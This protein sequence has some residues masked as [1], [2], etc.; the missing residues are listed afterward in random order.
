MG[1]WLR[2]FP[3]GHRFSSQLPQGSPQLSLI[4]VPEDSMTSSGP[5]GP[6]F[7][8]CTD[9]HAGKISIRIK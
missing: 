1:L 3:K 7:T 2:A 9:I 5:R 4:P 8:W 6:A